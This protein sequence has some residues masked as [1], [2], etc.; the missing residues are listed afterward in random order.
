MSMIEHA[1]RRYDTSLWSIDGLRAAGIPQGTIDDTQ[2]TTAF[3]RIDCAAGRARSRYVSPGALVDQE[4]R[5]AERAVESWRDAGS[6]AGD[7]P[8]EIA[9]GADYAGVDN[10]TAAQQ[11]EAAAK[12]YR[13]G[14]AKIRRLR[15]NGKAAVAA[16][17][18]EGIEAA[19][20]RAITALNAVEPPPEIEAL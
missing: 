20:D 18:G 19:A 10:E 14:I 5:E 13:E 12:A 2:R 3:D 11:I 8:D 15:L 4:Y 9:S 1:G 16:A 17:E 6:P 7:V